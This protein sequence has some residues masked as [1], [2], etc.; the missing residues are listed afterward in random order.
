M[1][2]IILPQMTVKTIICIQDK[3][4]SRTAITKGQLK[5]LCH[6]PDL[7]VSLKEAEK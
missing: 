4:Y 6:L 3:C 2:E 1:V 7:S 5:E